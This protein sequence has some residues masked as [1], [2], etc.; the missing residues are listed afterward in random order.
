MSLTKTKARPKQLSLTQLEGLPSPRSACN[1]EPV[2][3][4]TF[5]EPS[6][7]DFGPLPWNSERASDKWG[8]ITLQSR[9]PVAV[10]VQCFVSFQ[11]KATDHVGVK[12]VINN[13]VKPGQCQSRVI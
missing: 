1:T 3:D 12:R 5:A 4:V 7:H 10:L 11:W 6:K 2:L 13:F 8:H 9:A